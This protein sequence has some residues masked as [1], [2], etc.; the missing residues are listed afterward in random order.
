MAFEVSIANRTR[1]AVD[2]P[3][4]STHDDLEE[5][6]RARDAALEVEGFTPVALVADTEDPER[7]NAEWAVC[8]LHGTF[9]G[10]GAE[11][12]ECGHAGV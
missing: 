8:G 12:E 2:L 4:D 9:D 1:G 3:D 10:L 11:C 5:A 7:G 6:L